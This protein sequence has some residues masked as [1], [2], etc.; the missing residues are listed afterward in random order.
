MCAFLVLLV[1]TEF[2]VAVDVVLC[3]NNDF[4]SL[5]NTE[6][7]DDEKASFYGGQ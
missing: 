2:D 6:K 5:T 7:K 1:A 4:C 3:C